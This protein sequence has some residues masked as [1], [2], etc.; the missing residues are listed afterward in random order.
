MSKI[1]LLIVWGF[2]YNYA[3]IQAK[4]F[5]PMGT[6]ESDDLSQDAAEN[7]ANKIVGEYLLKATQ[8]LST[9]FSV[10]QSEIISREQ[11]DI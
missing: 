5:R 2:Q 7:R 10:F 3:G 1:G 8:V 11:E 9:I 4:D 6:S